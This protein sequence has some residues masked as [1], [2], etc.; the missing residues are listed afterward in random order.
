MQYCAN[1]DNVGNLCHFCVTF[2]VC[3]VATSLNGVARHA[4]A[5]GKPNV[6]VCYTFIF[7]CFASHIHGRGREKCCRRECEILAW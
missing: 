2:A 3:E 4:V 1:G 6:G 7:A 5:L